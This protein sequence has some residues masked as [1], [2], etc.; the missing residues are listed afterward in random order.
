MV[1]TVQHK[2]SLKA[3][4]TATLTVHPTP[5]QARAVRHTHLA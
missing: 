2:Q 4:V 1:V 5:E 3:T